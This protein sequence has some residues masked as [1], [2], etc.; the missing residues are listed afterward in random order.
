MFC[1]YHQNSEE[2]HVPHLLSS[3]Y[4]QFCQ[5]WQESTSNLLPIFQNASKTYNALAFT[6]YLSHF[7]IVR[8][9]SLTI[10][11]DQLILIT[12]KSDFASSSNKKLIIQHKFFFSS[13]WLEICRGAKILASPKLPIH[14]ATHIHRF[15]A[16]DSGLSLVRLKTLFCW[17]LSLAFT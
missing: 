12:I 17:F 5:N 6:Q 3:S 13:N 14:P 1:A 8:L 9:L 15:K 11:W 7:G 2:Q 10:C 16:F 4:S